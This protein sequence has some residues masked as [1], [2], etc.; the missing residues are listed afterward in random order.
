M[1]NRIRA[2]WERHEILLAGVLAALF[3]ILLFL[4]EAFEGLDDRLNSALFQAAFSASASASPPPI[5]IIKKDEHTSALLGKAPS[6][7]EFASI[8]RQLN[9]DHAA[10]IAFD[11]L[12]QGTKARE[13]DDLL[14]NAI[15]S[16]QV[17]LILAAQRNIDIRND[18]EIL[19]H[20]QGA[21][22]R[23]GKELLHRRLQ[24]SVILPE[25]K[26]Q[27]SK[28]EVGFINIGLGN[29]GFV[30]RVPVF[31]YLSGE[32]RLAPSF[33]LLSA[34]LFLE[35]NGPVE[36]RGKYHE[37]M[38]RELTRLLPIVKRGEDPVEFRLPDRTIP[39]DISGFMRINFFGAAQPDV[40][41][42]TVFPSASFHDCFDRPNLDWY[43]QRQ[44]GLAE[45]LAPA[46][47]TSASE[48][49]LPPW[50]DRLCMIGPFEKGDYDYYETP[51]TLST[52]FTTYREPLMGVEIHANAALTILT[53]HFFFTRHLLHTCIGAFL[54]CIFLSYLLFRRAPLNGFII[55]VVFLCAIFGAAFYL[56]HALRQVFSLSPFLS[57]L[58][59]VWFYHAL[60]G[61][62]HQRR[63]AAQTKDMFQRFVSA[64]VV[65][66]MLENPDAVRPG[67]QKAELTVFFSDVAGFTSISE[68]LTA[69]NLVVLLN[70]YLGA[71]T[72]ILFKHGGTLDKFIGDAVMAFWNFPRAQEDHAIRGC[73]CAIEMQAKIS[74]LQKVWA[75]RGFP[76]VSARC[77][78]NTTTAIVGYMGSTNAQMNFTCMGDGVNLASDLEAGNK[79][80][81]TLLMI[82]E[83]TYQRAKERVSVRYLDIVEA[84]GE[85]VPVKVY[86]LVCEKGKEAPDWFEMLREYDLGIALY[87]ERKWH[88][89][90]EAFENLLSR[91]PDDG[92]SKTYLH[93]C[94]EYEEHP[95]PADWNGTAAL[96]H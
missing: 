32:D 37:G 57:G 90:A 31:Q 13:I 93:R 15:A 80:Y 18:Q 4:A 26:F 38:E 2:F 75:T 63:M 72:D 55:L 24:I 88:E 28:T 23:Q 83:H 1:I 43:K 66:Y 94:H 16:C 54:F 65:Q 86:Q 79:G 10:V 74:E 50:S 67:G 85:P 19:T 21:Q 76:K 9:D 81:E 69:E 5:C 3:S 61:Y 39:L 46:L 51:L 84:A 89:A 7:R 20:E 34:V 58:P 17:P 91:W 30:N 62:L 27:S 14:V 77:G 8:F 41:G 52:P 47:F 78:L 71:M 42:K 25:K 33:S 56:F 6:R 60:S 45:K 53:G 36:F 35:K 87:Q 48:A 29:R 96:G 73:L 92:P 95:P 70:E 68:A 12:L 59:L 64:E 49:Y 82:S 44:P 40:A 22:G 11:F